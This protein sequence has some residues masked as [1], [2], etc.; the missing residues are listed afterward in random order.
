MPLKPGAPSATTVHPHSRGENIRDAVMQVGAAGSSPLA[1]GKFTALSVQLEHSRFIP[2]RA[3]KMRAIQPGLDQ[4]R[5]HPH[6]RGENTTEFTVTH[7]HC[8]SSPLA[9]GKSGDVAVPHLPEGFIPTRAGKIRTAEAERSARPVHPHS[10]G[11]NLSE[12]AAGIG[13][14][15]SSPLARGKYTTDE[16][17]NGLPGFIPTRAG[18]IGVA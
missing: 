1:R 4:A 16:V 12:F 7:R 13:Q 8:G 18:K 14:W 9:R 10:R 17:A 11:E 6:S 2:T 15:G 5:V 3:G